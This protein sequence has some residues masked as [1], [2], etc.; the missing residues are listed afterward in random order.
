MDLAIY[1]DD[2][3]IAYSNT[4][5]LKSFKD[6]LTRENKIGVLSTLYRALNME[7]TRTNYGGLFLNQRLYTEDLLKRFG[8]LSTD[9]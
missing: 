1:V 6:N 4:T 8:A 5:L 3:I 7:I 9:G 2:L